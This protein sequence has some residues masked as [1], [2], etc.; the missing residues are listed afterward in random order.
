MR[1]FLSYAS[2]DE[3]RVAELA[4]VLRAGGFDPWWDDRLEP[5]DNWKTELRRG[6]AASEAFLYLISS[7]SV[8]SEWC[9]WELAQAVALAKPIVPILLRSETPLPTPVRSLQYLDISRGMDNMDVA[10]LVGKL[11]R[12]EQSSPRETLH[13]VGTPSGLP[14]RFRQPLPKEY[15]TIAQAYLQPLSP[16]SCL[17]DWQQDSPSEL[18]TKGHIVGIDFGTSL[19]AIAVYH[20]DTA[21]LIPNDFG[22]MSTPSAV[23]ISSDGTVLVGQRALDFLL[24]RPERGVLEVKRLFGHDLEREYGGPPVLEVDGIAYRPVDFA[25]LILRQL[26]KDAEAYLQSSVHRAV[27]TAPAYFDQ[28]Q[29]AALMQAARFAGLHVERVL[30]EPVAACMAVGWNDREASALV[31]DLGGGTFDASVLE[32][33]EGVFEV[34]AVNGDTRLGGADF[35][36][37]LV[38]YYVQEFKEATAVDL[39]NDA[40]ALMRLREAVERAKIALSTAKTALVSVPFIASTA[41]ATLHLD[42]ELT[43]AR[44][45][46]LTHPLVARTV[47]LCHAALE[48]AG[49]SSETIDRV[50]VVGRATRAS[51][52]SIALGDLFGQ[53]HRIAPDHVVALGAAVQGGVLAGRCRHSLL[54]DTVTHTLRVQL[55]GGRTTPIVVRNSVIPLRTSVDLAVRSHEQ[56]EL[57]VRIMAGDSSWS[58]QDAFLTE[59][60]VPYNAKLGSSQQLHLTVDIGAS[61]NVRIVVRDANQ[62]ELTRQEFSLRQESNHHILMEQSPAPAQPEIMMPILDTPF[63]LGPFSEADCMDSG[64]VQR[65]LWLAITDLV[66]TNFG[67]N[68]GGGWWKRLDQWLVDNSSGEI[69][70]A[71]IKQNILPEYPFERELLVDALEERFGRDLT[72]LRRCSSPQS[73]SRRLTDILKSP[74]A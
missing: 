1:L 39:R 40:T 24:R 31:Y 14:A 47:E 69:P 74:T 49:F 20:H 53:R 41:S 15:R 71:I 2:V 55:E 29:F 36:R 44:C 4:A 48:D 30:P 51:S 66:L 52:I 62:V 60:K 58:E 61:S 10:R 38:D 35:D 21:E 64:S 27:L 43:R 68:A 26:R 9:Q 12:L 18:P 13:T 28:S 70:A 63:K 45:N 54:L 50:L 25:A 19:S 46:E 6:I 32:C 37:I 8:E 33:G 11:A 67:P 7:D 59:S 65:W 72:A 5:G 16:G 42:S 23:A 22:E 56:K 17:Y 73:M 34:L 57:L 3:I